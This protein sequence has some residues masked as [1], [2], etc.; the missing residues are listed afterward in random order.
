MA[1]HHG[2]PGPLHGPPGLHLVPEACDDLRR[3]A[4]EGQPRRAHLRRECRVLSEKAVPGMDRV[5]AARPGRV[6]EP[7]GVEVTLAGIRRTDR[8]RLIGEPNVQRP[9]VGL[10]V[11]RDGPEAEVAARADDA[12]RDFA[13]VGD[14]HRPQ[15]YIRNTP[16]RIRLTG[17]LSAADR[18][19][20]RTVRVSAGSMI[21]S[22]HSRAV[23]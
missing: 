7:A 10:R 8:H 1:G 23:L 15:R 5:G 3:R 20:A 21:P 9:A 2:E 12:D 17:A 19:S 13:A 18:L 11:D 6:D 16:G 22:S 14:E 4:D